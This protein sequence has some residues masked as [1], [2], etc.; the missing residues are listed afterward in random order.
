MVRRIL[1]STEIN[2]HVMHPLC[3]HHMCDQRYLNN[4]I[5]YN[6][7]EDKTYNLIRTDLQVQGGNG[8]IPH[9]HV[10]PVET[11]K[12]VYNMRISEIHYEVDVMVL[13]CNHRQLWDDIFVK[14]YDIV[15][16]KPPGRRFGT[17]V[18]RGFQHVHPDLHD[19]FYGYMQRMRHDLTVDISFYIQTSCVSFIH[20]SI[21]DACE[22]VNVAKR[23]NDM[24]EIG[25]TISA[26][27]SP[28]RKSLSSS[29]MKGLI[30]CGAEGPSEPLVSRVHEKACDELIHYVLEDHRCTKNVMF[31]VRDKL[32]NIM[33]L[34]LD[35]HKSMW[36]VVCRLSE[37]IQADDET[38]FRMTDAYV[39][40][41]NGFNTNYRPIYH[42]ERF[43]VCLLRIAHFTD[44]DDR[45]G[46]KLT[47]GIDKGLWDI[48]SPLTPTFPAHSG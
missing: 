48:E 12:I 5:Y 44:T 43:V 42:L 17:V 9:E 15:R 24:V 21:L 1:S 31:N 11:S 16:A 8:S 28:L 4:K 35:M 37:E 32:Y 6:V 30:D 18:V 13:G 22:H 33:F 39:R 19:V 40:C 23:Y 29:K 26:Q 2:L 7:D 47:F 20:R 34:Y 36:Y 41:F 45:G 10:I 3:V 38:M 25:R 14:I 27:S 46:D